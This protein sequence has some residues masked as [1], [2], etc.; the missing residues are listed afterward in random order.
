M[1]YQHI[2]VDEHDGIS[3]SSTSGSTA[4]P[5]V[6]DEGGYGSASFQ[7]YA[8]ISIEETVVRSFNIDTDLPPPFG[9]FEAPEEQEKAPN[10]LLK[11][12]HTQAIV[13]LRGSKKANIEFGINSYFRRVLE[14][15]VAQGASTPFDCKIAAQGQNA[16]VVVPDDFEG[17][18]AGKCKLSPIL[19]GRS[20]CVLYDAEQPHK[21]RYTIA[22]R[23]SNGIKTLSGQ[24]GEEPSFSSVT[25]L[26]KPTTQNGGVGSNGEVLICVPSEYTDEQREK[27][28]REGEYE[29]WTVQRAWPFRFIHWHT[30]LLIRYGSIGDKIL[31]CF[32]LSVFLFL[33]VGLPILLT[34]IPKNSS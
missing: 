14:I 30:R 33:T 3:R 8:Y 5:P 19:A 16:T 7:N 21:T 34:L 22:P 10:L 24:A 17:T 25:N 2:P 12:E 9:R 29:T 32:I 28:T 27:D 26:P 18:V 11:A 1:A 6:Y 23:T 13:N 20:T 31:Y 4:F 15:R